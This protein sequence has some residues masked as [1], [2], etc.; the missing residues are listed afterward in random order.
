MWSGLLAGYYRERWAT[1]RDF[2]ERLSQDTGVAATG[3]TSDINMTAWAIAEEN[4][5]DTWA[6]AVTAFPVLPNGD[7]VTLSQAAYTKYSAM[8]LEPPSPP[9]PSPSPLPPSNSTPPGYKW[10]TGGYWKDG[11][12]HGTGHTVATCAATC[13]NA[14]ASCVAFELSAT[15]ACYVFVSISG[16]FIKNSACK[17]FTK[18]QEH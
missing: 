7:A 9:P 6:H 10:H 4:L 3:A 12:S 16:S 5:T 13:T 1:F 8:L 15:Q 11:I 14:K 2:T 17:T 18:K